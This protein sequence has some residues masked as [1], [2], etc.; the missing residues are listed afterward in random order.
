MSQ[1]PYATDEALAAACTAGDQHA[2]R[3]LY[4]RFRLPLY[5]LCLRY[6]RDSQEAEDF[7]HDG[8]L[9]VF[10]DLGQYR[11]TGA[12]G[13]W[14]RRV[15]LNT[16]LLHLRRRPTILPASALPEVGDTV[17]PEPD[18]LEDFAPERIYE[19]IRQLPDGYRT[20]FNL[21]YLEG[22]SHQQIARELDISEGSSK[23][24]LYKA[25]RHL[26]KGVEAAGIRGKMRVS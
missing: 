17:E 5:R 9:R 10:R 25:K 4:E 22:F 1:V 24:Q 3:M 23:S 15:V 2:Q 19:L 14:V 11:G 21:F 16:V 8:L 26:R 13:G 6:A 18:Y 12:L 7:L 20:V